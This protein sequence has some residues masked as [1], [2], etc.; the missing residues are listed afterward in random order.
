MGKFNKLTEQNVS[1]GSVAIIFSVLLPI[2]TAFGTLVM[3]VGR[4]F[5]LSQRFNTAITSALIAAANPSVPDNNNSQLDV[6]NQILEQN[7]NYSNIPVNVS[8]TKNGNQM[9]LTGTAQVNSLLPELLD[10]TIGNKI[11]SRTLSHQVTVDLPKK[12]IEIALVVS[13]NDTPTQ[14]P[15]F[16]NKLNAVLNEI[17]NHPRVSALYVSL[18]PFREGV[19]APYSLI[20]MI[21][22]E[23]AP[24]VPSGV[25]STS[26]S[27]IPM[28]IKWLYHAGRQVPEQVNLL[29]ITDIRAPCDQS[30]LE[31]C[32]TQ[33]PLSFFL[34]RLFTDSSHVSKN[35]YGNP[36]ILAN[37]N[38]EDTDNPPSWGRKWGITFLPPAMDWYTGTNWL[39][40][41]D[42]TDE[43]LP[44][45]VS[46]T[47]DLNKIVTVFSQIKPLELTVG[48]A[49]WDDGSNNFKK[50]NVNNLVNLGMAWGYRTLSPKWRT[51]WYDNP[52]GAEV[53]T[54]PYNYNTSNHQKIIILMTG[55]SS[56]LSP[57]AQ[58]F[59]DVNKTS[60]YFPGPWGPYLNIDRTW[61][62]IKQLRQF[63]PQTDIPKLNAALSVNTRIRLNNRKVVFAINLIKTILAGKCVNDSSQCTGTININTTPT[64]YSCAASEA[65]SCTFTGDSTAAYDASLAT[66]EAAAR[67]INTRKGYTDHFTSLFYENLIFSSFTSSTFRI[68]FDP[69]TMGGS[70]YDYIP[71][72]FDTFDS[73]E[74]WT[75]PGEYDIP[76]IT[77][78]GQNQCLNNHMF[79]GWPFIISYWWHMRINLPFLTSIGDGQKLEKTINKAI[80]YLDDI[81]EERRMLET[82]M[83][84]SE[85]MLALLDLCAYGYLG[86]GLLIEYNGAIVPTPPNDGY[87]SLDRSSA[88]YNI[89]QAQK[90]LDDLLLKTCNNA[91]NNGINIYLLLNGDKTTTTKNTILSQCAT[92]LMMIFEAPQNSMASALDEIKNHILSDMPPPTIVSSS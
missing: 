63:N 14:D 75:C 9:T 10:S 67:A 32:R 59:K 60:G 69:N 56:K 84:E 88:I 37:F 65:S 2:L 58:S 12:S 39:G 4:T 92:S 47:S 34:V 85:R 42:H 24:P 28:T 81:I 36:L 83:F 30:M 25:G 35:F 11:V 57:Q 3:E 41:G 52:N 38:G 43:A 72:T 21:T 90:A 64:A 27:N 66:T 20:P 50:S 68:L 22:Q 23:A 76:S 7:F 74:A 61:N 40:P 79:V 15:N 89:N 53:A 82:Q 17:K 44:S 46:L 31:T 91:K 16:V 5:Y 26:L 55:S 33:D 6:I 8:L 1:K 77:A 78:T 54:L 45:L 70:G 19:F 73:E 80:P 13:C 51:L 87:I 48:I 49:L 18:I 62:N 86:D 71:Y 29:G